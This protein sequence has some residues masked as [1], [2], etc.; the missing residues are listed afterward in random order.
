MTLSFSDYLF[1]ALRVS[2]VIVLVLLPCYTFMQPFRRFCMFAIAVNCVEFLL[3]HH[4]TAYANNF[5]F[6]RIVE[7]CWLSFVLSGF[8]KLIIP[9]MGELVSKLPYL[10][11]VAFVILNG[12]PSGGTS[13]MLFGQFVVVAGN[14]LWMIMVVIR[15]RTERFID[16]AISITY[17]AV[18]Y[19]TGSLINIRFVAPRLD[20]IIGLVPI[21]M[22][23][24]ATFRY[25]PSAFNRPTSNVI[26][27]T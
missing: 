23:I 11:T 24:V 13:K 26:L 25:D 2:G 16:L 9:T 1:W 12:P 20:G 27:R 17:L 18:A 8:A 21:I 15:A 5:W 10:A 14:L 22:I 6:M 19:V 3:R 7:I 4:P